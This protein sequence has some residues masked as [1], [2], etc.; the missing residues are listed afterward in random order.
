[1]TCRHSQQP[2]AGVCLNVTGRRRPPYRPTAWR[3][4]HGIFGYAMDAKTSKPVRDPATGLPI[5]TIINYMLPD[6]RDICPAQIRAG[7]K[8][9]CLNTA[10]RGAMN[11]V[12]KSRAAKTARF[13]ADPDLFLEQCVEEIEAFI[14]FCVRRHMVPACRFNGT[15]DR[16]DFAARLAARFPSVIFYD[17]TKLTSW[18]ERYAAGRW[19]PFN[20]HLTLSWSGASN[21]YRDNVESVAG[22]WSDLNLAVVFGTEEIRDSWIETGRLFLGRPVIS[23]TA[24]DCRIPSIDGRGVIVGLVAKGKAKRDRTGFVTRHLPLFGDYPRPTVTAEP[25]PILYRD[26]MDGATYYA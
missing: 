15:S 14:R 21:R 24:H 4:K 23:G 26:E 20:Y 9:P 6:G 13:R 3:G 16:P 19:L 12:Q 22:I 2:A 11:S 18:A 10:G 5:A 1:M 25:A 7:C 8:A 17:Y